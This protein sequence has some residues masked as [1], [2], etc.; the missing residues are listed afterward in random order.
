MI[1]LELLKV[2]STGSGRKRRFVEESLVLS[3]PADSWTFCASC[4]LLLLVLDSTGS[5]AN[6]RTFRI[7]ESTKVGEKCRA[8]VAGGGEMSDIVKLTS[9]EV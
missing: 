3:T 6:R 4:C 5:T 9:W 2:V 1:C 7:E 8:V